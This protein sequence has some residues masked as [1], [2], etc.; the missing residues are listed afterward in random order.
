MLK[1]EKEHLEI[2]EGERVL[3][4]NGEEQLEKGQEGKGRE[5]KGEREKTA[6]ESGEK[7]RGDWEKGERK[8]AGKWW[9]RDRLVSECLCSVMG[10]GGRG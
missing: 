9:R 5:G 2:N 8:G 4:N 3:K 10:S 1:K 6:K 7:E